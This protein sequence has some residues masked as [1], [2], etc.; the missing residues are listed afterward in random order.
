MKDWTVFAIAGES[1]A[2]AKVIIDSHSGRVFGAHLFGKGADENI[3]M[4][5]MAIRFG[6]SA[7]ELRSMVYAY[8]TFASALPYTLPEIEGK[9]ELRKAG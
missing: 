3:H 6:I 8:P 1:I 5:A 2:K 7:D 9:Q 4:F